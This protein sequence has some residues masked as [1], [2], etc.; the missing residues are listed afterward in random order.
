M[1]AYENV[2][3]AAVSVFALALTVIAV[4]AWRRTKDGHLLFLA[5]AFVLFF[6][7]GVLLT[8]ALFQ[9]WSDL[10]QLVVVSG[11]FDLGIL[12]SFYAFTLRR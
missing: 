11:V 9:G 8:V 5:G 7:K 1:V 6:F 4:L 2:I 10:A 3:L 12:G